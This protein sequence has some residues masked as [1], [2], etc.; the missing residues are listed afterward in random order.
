LFRDPDTRDELDTFLS[1]MESTNVK[2]LPDVRIKLP[3]SPATGMGDVEKADYHPLQ[4]Y[5][6]E[7]ARVPSP[8]ED[9][10][11]TRR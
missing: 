11:A 10:E 7:V 1:Q 4:V 9:R 6:R 8:S 2:L 3:A 5:L